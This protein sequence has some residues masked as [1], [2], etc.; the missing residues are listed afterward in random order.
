ML[1]RIIWEKDDGKRTAWEKEPK[2]GQYYWRK[3]SDKSR[4]KYTKEDAD[5][6][7]KDLTTERRYLDRQVRRPFDGNIFLEIV[8]ENTSTTQQ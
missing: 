5:L 6:W 8:K 1:Y 7:L 2:D 3:I 4:Q